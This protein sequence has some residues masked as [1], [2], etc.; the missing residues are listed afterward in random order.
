M[1]P[2]K[3]RKGERLKASWLNALLM[4]VQAARNLGSDGSLNIERL[5]TGSLLR[6]TRKPT[7]GIQYKLD[8]SSGETCPLFGL[9]AC[10]STAPIWIGDN[11]Y[12]ETKKPSTTFRRSYVVNSDYAVIGGTSGYCYATNI[13]ILAYDTGTPALDET[14]GAKPSQ[15]TASL[16]YPG[17]RCLG[18]LDA[19]NKWM[20]AVPEPILTLRAKADAAINANSSGTCSIYIGAAG[21]ESDSTINITAYTKELPQLSTDELITIDFTNGQ[22]YIRTKAQGFLGK[23]DSS[24]AKSASGTVSLYHG[25]AGSE[26]DTTFNVT[27]YNKFAAVGSGKWVWVAFDG[28]NWYLTG[29]E[30]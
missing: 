29:A 19:T 28:K 25:T 4:E 15:F 21:S 17:F 22:P 6:V 16:G 5:P 8:E 10:D 1:L 2:R 30:C 24:H 20:L 18:I 26:S 11:P 13:V 12:I 3:L 27:A 14:W 7:G 9:M 23:T